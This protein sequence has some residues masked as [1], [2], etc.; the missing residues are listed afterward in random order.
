MGQEAY[1]LFE[2]KGGEREAK[3][4]ID[5]LELF[6]LLANV[7]DVKSLCDPSC[8]YDTRSVKSSGA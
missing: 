7:A 1:L 8:K 4:F 3:E 2:I 5:R 6:S